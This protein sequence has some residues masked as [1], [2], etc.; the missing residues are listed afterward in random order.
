MS[1]FLDSHW[2][3]SVYNNQT[4]LILKKIVNNYSKVNNNANANASQPIQRLCTRIDISRNDFLLIRIKL[5]FLF[6][7]SLWHRMHHSASRSV[8]HHRLDLVLLIVWIFIGITSAVIVSMWNLRNSEPDP[9]VRH[10]HVWCILCLPD[11][12]K[13]NEIVFCVGHIGQTV[14]NIAQCIYALRL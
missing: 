11:R 10:V 4:I 9:R 5:E 6:A 3:G 14:I 13:S 8:I 2:C 12:A 1:Q 7:S